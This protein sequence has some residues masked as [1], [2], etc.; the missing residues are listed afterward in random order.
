MCNAI[1]THTH[2]QTKRKRNENEEE[3]KQRKQ[4]QLQLLHTRQRST[5]NGAYEA[6]NLIFFS[7]TRLSTSI[8]A[9]LLPSNELKHLFIIMLKKKFAIKGFKCPAKRLSMNFDYHFF[10]RCQLRRSAF[11]S[12]HRTSFT[13]FTYKVFIITYL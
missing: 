12:R 10:Y 8:Y 2:N 6:Y 5:Y 1:T 3:K 11:V 7:L 9:N 4:S 13:I